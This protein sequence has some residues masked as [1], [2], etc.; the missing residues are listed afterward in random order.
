MKKFLSL[1]CAI[2]VAIGAMTASAQSSALPALTT[3]GL[4]QIVIGM[5]KS[6][7]PSSVTGIYNKIVYETA[8]PYDMDC[9]IGLAGW[10]T[11]SLQGKE[12]VAVFIGSDNKVCGI[13]VFTPKVKSIDGVYVGMPVTKLEGIKGLEYEVG[14]EELYF[15]SHGGSV[16]EY[17]IGYTTPKAVR[18]MCVGVTY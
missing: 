6:D 15:S 7:I 2:A 11:C 13:S 10:Y 16:I 3:K 4:G 14:M 12:T 8:P 18:L 17:L 1:I 5:K 9:P